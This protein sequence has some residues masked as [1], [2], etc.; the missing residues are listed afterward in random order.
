M[1]N[2]FAL[3]AAA[4]LVAGSAWS[5]LVPNAVAVDSRAPLCS[6]SASTPTYSSR[7]ISGT[8][9][10]DCGTSATVTVKVMEDLTSWPD[11]ELESASKT[12]AKV[13]VTATFR[14]PSGSGHHYNSY[15]HTI[16]STGNTLESGRKLWYCQ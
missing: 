7:K 3:S 2:L 9:G 13:S 16:S 14:C 15:T 5:V 11:E 6:L 4:A 8:G 12:G 1:R 10:R